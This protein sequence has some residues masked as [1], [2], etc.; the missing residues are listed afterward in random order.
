LLKT[1]KFAHMSYLRL[2]RKAIFLMYEAAG[3]RLKTLTG[4]LEWILI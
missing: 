3:D 1:L 2:K 4:G